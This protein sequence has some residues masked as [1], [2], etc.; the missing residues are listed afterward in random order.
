MTLIK[1]IKAD[2]TAGDEN[3]VLPRM[4]LTVSIAGSAE[5]MQR[6]IDFG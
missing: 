4:N 1:L 5:K 2:L 6:T 3:S